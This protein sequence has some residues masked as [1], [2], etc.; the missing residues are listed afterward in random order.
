MH[1]T[2]ILKNLRRENVWISNVNKPP[3]GQTDSHTV[4][5]TKFINLFFF[6][7]KNSILPR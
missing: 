6:A 3:D 5:Y 4:K 7:L 2:L 1:K